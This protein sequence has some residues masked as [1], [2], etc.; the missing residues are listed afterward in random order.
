MQELSNPEY[1]KKIE[2]NRGSLKAKIQKKKYSTHSKSQGN[3]KENRWTEKSDLH[4]EWYQ[5][6]IGHQSQADY[7]W[8]ALTP[9]KACL[10]VKD[11]IIIR[12]YKPGYP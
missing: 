9:I 3:E 8:L 2:I 10:T 7:H 5:W 1:V 6:I 4:A 12:S 11:L